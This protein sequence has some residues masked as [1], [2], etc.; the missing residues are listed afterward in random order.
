MSRARVSQLVDAGCP[1]T[2]YDAAERWRAQ[3][4]GQ[5]TWAAKREQGAMPVLTAP[6]SGPPPPD[7]VL[8]DEASKVD[9]T[10][11]GLDEAVEKQRVLVQLT[12]NKYIKAFKDN[13][14]RQ[15]N[16]YATYDKTLQTLVKLEEKALARSIA[17]RK[18]IDKSAAQEQFVRVLSMVRQ[19]LEQMEFVLAPATNPGNPAK[20]LK[21]IREWKNKALGRIAGYANGDAEQGEQTASEP[22]LEGYD[23]VIEPE[24]LPEP[25]SNDNQQPR[26]E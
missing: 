26:A 7:A 3:R 24:T 14:P 13:D 10:T 21:A 9:K 22:I 4:K 8:G 19:E 1:L 23:E 16:H 11:A 17:T 15:G 6:E 20:A 25:D 2:D 18:F 5:M 12:R